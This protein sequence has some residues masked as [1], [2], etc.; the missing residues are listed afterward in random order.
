MVLQ[1]L[2]LINQASTSAVGP[3]AGVHLLHPE[4]HC[5]QDDEA[6]IPAGL[7]GEDHPLGDGGQSGGHRCGH[8]EGHGR[9]L[10]Q[11]AGVAGQ[12]EGVTCLQ[13][14]G[15]AAKGAG[16][17]RTGRALGV[18]GVSWIRRQLDPLETLG[19]KDMEALQHARTLAALVVLLVADGTLHICGLHQAGG[20]C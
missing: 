12:G 18:R 19:A 5:G 6:R 8:A 7:Q 3:I 13:R 9:Q 11:D 4:A 15:V 1:H 20:G 17:G 2:H 14:G 16:D 10:G